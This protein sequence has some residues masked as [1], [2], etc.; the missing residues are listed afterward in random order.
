LADVD[1]DP[2]IQALKD[3]YSRNRAWAKRGSYQTKLSPRQEQ[4]FQGWVWK[5]KIPYYLHFPPDQSMQDYD[6]RG[7]WKDMKAGDLEAKQDPTTL[8]FPDKYKTPYHESF[9][10]QSKYATPEA[11]SWTGDYLFDKNNNLVYPKDAG[12]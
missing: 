2:E 4:E 5:N 3:N 10:N 12:M 11:P 9:S 6:M 1:V 7:F 8:H